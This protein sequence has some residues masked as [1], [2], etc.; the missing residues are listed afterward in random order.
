MRVLIRLRQAMTKMTYFAPGASRI[1][2]ARYIDR[3]EAII[4]RNWKIIYGLTV[5]RIKNRSRERERER[6][7]NYCLATLGNGHD[8]IRSR[9]AIISLSSRP[10]L[11][12]FSADAAR[13]LN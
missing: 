9:M 6:E 13:K 7:S 1:S 8:P 5:L 4:S 12:H 10:A 11:E 3:G 2:K